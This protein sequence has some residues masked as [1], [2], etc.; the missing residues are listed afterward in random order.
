MKAGRYEWSAIV[1]LAALTLS[2]FIGIA[3]AEA[4]TAAIGERVSLSG[5]AIGEDTVYVFMT[6]PGVPSEGSR[7]D[8]SLSPVVSGNPDTFT[9]VPVYDGYWNYSWNTGR[10]SG[11]LAEGD[12]TVYVATRPVSVSDL[13]GVPYSD[14]RI[15][16]FRPPTTGSLSVLSSPS[17]AQVSVNGKYAGDTPLN[18]TALAPGDYEIEVALQG[19]LPMTEKVTI[20]AGGQKVTEFLLRPVTPETTA[21]NLPVGTQ[22]A[23]SETPLPVPTTVASFPHL[24]IAIGFLLGALFCRAGR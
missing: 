8:S 18:L 11:G 5:K 14:I 15:R 12:Y 4:G 3:A 1:L 23:S 24:A 6:G 16:L 10:V 17:P 19:Y 22:M 20:R 7:M 21:T 9:Q 13:A 2:L